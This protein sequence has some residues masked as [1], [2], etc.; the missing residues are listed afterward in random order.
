MALCLFLL[1]KA[2]QSG[3]GLPYLTLFA[4]LSV[5]N[6]FQVI[7]YVFLE[8]SLT[9]AIYA[10]D[11]YLIAIYFLFTHFMQ[12]ALGLSENDNVYWTKYLYIPPAILTALHI[13]GLMVES[14]RIE[15]NTVLH[16]DGIY[17]FTFDIFVLLAS[18]T[19]IVTLIAN[20]RRINSSGILRSRN[21][22]AIISF[23]PPII[24]GMT[25]IILSNTRSI[26]RA[27]QKP[28]MGMLPV[29]SVPQQ[30][31]EWMLLLANFKLRVRQ[32]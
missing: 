19:T 28:L 27:Q 22:I 7:I 2:Y 6:F 26:T 16:N 9:I 3:T 10:A 14:Y 5:I 30:L 25:L 17:A 23:I 8:H 15:D 31:A 24:V 1:H 12:I 13:S 18:V 20:L 29:L 32:W 11:T 21:V 4:N